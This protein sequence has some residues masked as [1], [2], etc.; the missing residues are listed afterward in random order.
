MECHLTFL[1]EG[2]TMEPA[3]T[4]AIKKSDDWWIGWVEELPGVNSQGRTRQELMDNLRD[5]LA[6]ALEMNRADARA[7]A[8]AA[9]E[10]VSV[11]P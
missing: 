4:A 9:Y 1:P 5:A 7:A 8:G 6:E 2:I 3:Y 10:E 11:V